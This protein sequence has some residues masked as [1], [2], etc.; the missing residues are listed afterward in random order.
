MA[1]RAHS[2]PQHEG[3]WL[4]RY[5]WV[6]LIVAAAVLGAWLARAPRTSAPGGAASTK[7]LTGYIGSVATVAEEWTRFQ[8]KVLQMP[9]VERQLQQANDRVA[10]HDYAAAVSLLEEVSRTGG[11]SGDF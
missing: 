7:V 10:A 8:G 5:W 11:G 2:N 1:G 3:S 6:G 4:A 9:E